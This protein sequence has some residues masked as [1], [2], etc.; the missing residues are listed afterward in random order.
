MEYDI[1]IVL[2]RDWYWYVIDLRLILLMWTQVRVYKH[3]LLGVSLWNAMSHQQTALEM[4]LRLE[5]LVYRQNESSQQAAEEYWDKIMRLNMDDLK[6]LLQTVQ[7]IG[8][9]GDQLNM[10]IQVQI[11][12]LKETRIM[13]TYH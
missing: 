11:K 1:D 9:K 3:C 5:S 12:H 10:F 4:A 8:L 2:N 13:K 7:R 6:E